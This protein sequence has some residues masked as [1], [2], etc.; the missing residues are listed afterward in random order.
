MSESTSNS[1][2]STD[3]TTDTGQYGNPAIVTGVAVAGMTV[4]TIAL[5]LRLYTRKI[6]LN[7]L[8]IDDYMAVLGWVGT[9]ILGITNCLLARDGLGKPPWELTQGMTPFFMEMYL[10][11]IIAVVAVLFIKLTFF[12]QFYRILR[13]NTAHPHL[14]RLYIA[15]VVLITCWLIA[16]VFVSAF[17]CI[18]VAAFWDHSIPGVC[19]DEA[20]PRWMS[21]IGN[22]ITD[23]IILILPV[24]VIWKLRLRPSQKWGLAFVFGLGIFVCIISILRVS[25]SSNNSTGAPSDPTPN[26]AWTMA[27]VFTGLLIACLAT[28]RPLI[29]RY[30]PSWRDITTM[31]SSTRARGQSSSSRTNGQGKAGTGMYSGG[32]LT[33][34]NTV[35]SAKGKDTANWLNLSDESCV[36]MG[37][38]NAVEEEEEEAKDRLVVSEVPRAYPPGGFAVTVTKNITVTRD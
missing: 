5:V 15:I 25:L 13:N 20:A 18:P 6:I 11:M 3:N 8:W 36:E 12:F 27:E 34:T 26:I 9:M 1:T 4:A 16:L 29:S 30:L 22:I 28:L 19:R 35:I 23:F 10:G 31:G 38:F 7:F 33:R 2:T 24:P 32:R 17:P 37:R 21:G 14:R